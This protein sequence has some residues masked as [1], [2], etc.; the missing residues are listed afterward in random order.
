LFLLLCVCCAVVDV[1]SLSSSS[2]WSSST[3]CCCRRRLHCG[4]PVDVAV[5]MGACPFVIVLVVDAVVVFA[6]LN[7]LMFVC[8]AASCVC[9]CVFLVIHFLMGLRVLPA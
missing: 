5:G 4:A 1:L 6:C 7:S 2:S 8:I 3:L 9:V